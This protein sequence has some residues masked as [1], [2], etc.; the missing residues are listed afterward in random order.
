MPEGAIE[1]NAANV[2]AEDGLGTL[3]YITFE[4][5]PPGAGF[6]TVM[7]AVPASAISEAG[8]AAVICKLLMKVVVRGLPF[9]FAVEL[10]TNPVPLIVR[11]N[12]A[13]PGAALVGTRG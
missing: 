11:V 1:F 6:V 8:I 4:A 7:E 9:Q 2:R 3:K 13:L 12:P 5:P 10:E